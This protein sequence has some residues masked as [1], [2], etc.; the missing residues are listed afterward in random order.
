MRRAAP[1]YKVMSA[2]EARVEIERLRKIGRDG[3]AAAQHKEE[4]NKQLKKLAL[5]GFASAGLKAAR[6]ANA[7]LAAEMGQ[8]LAKVQNTMGRGQKEFNVEVRFSSV[9]AR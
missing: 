7:A 6:G 4:E 5:G 8:A 9:G 3:L 1:G 2:E